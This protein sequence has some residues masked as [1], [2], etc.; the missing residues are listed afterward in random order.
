M[1]RRLLATTEIIT[2]IVH[3]I[4]TATAPL[5]GKIR[6]LG[7]LRQRT[8]IKKPNTMRYYRHWQQS[9]KDKNFHFSPSNKK[10]VRKR[11]NS[12]G[13]CR[14]ET[15]IH[16][17]PTVSPYQMFDTRNQAKGRHRPHV[18]HHTALSH[19]R[20]AGETARKITPCSSK[21]DHFAYCW[22]TKTK[23]TLASQTAI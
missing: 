4:K 5:W 21:T 1:A 14:K 23:K 6:I 18:C 10:T 2:T 11:T 17:A 20:R 13:C 15:V 8:K 3:K 9:H 22:F 12:E 7:K 16:T 19:S